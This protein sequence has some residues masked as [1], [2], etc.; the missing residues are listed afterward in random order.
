MATRHTFSYRENSRHGAL[1]RK[2]QTGN[3]AFSVACLT[4][5]QLLQCKGD[6]F[7]HW[8]IQRDEHNRTYCTVQRIFE[9]LC[10]TLK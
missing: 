6:R 9:L 1:Q 4:S 7:V 5:N 2:K 10:V 3:V 8:L